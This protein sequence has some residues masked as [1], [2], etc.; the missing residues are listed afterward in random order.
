MSPGR[1][2]GTSFYQKLKCNY[3]LA[4]LLL[5]AGFAAGLAAVFAAGLPLS[6]V[7]LLA[8]DFVPGLAVVDVD[9]LVVCFDV[10]DACALAP[11]AMAAATNKSARFL[12]VFICF[13]F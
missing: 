13:V 4:A 3:F 6:A 9:V 2:A 5:A 11:I 7:E 1:Q 10:V 8:A 12:M